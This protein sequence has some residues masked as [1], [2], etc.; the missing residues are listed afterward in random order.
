MKGADDDFL[1]V[2]LL[3]INL[4]SLKFVVQT[5]FHFLGAQFKMP[6]RHLL[7]KFEIKSY[8]LAKFELTL[9]Y[10]K[11]TLQNPYGK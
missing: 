7:V 10:A 1:A 8:Q 3:S 4:N 2:D 5:V 6:K 9:Q 11:K